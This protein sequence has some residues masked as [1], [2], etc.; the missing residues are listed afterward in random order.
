MKDY[1]VTFANNKLTI[2]TAATKRAARQEAERLAKA[3]NTT[4]KKIGP[5]RIVGEG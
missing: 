4:V 2:I 3:R 5:G 1:K